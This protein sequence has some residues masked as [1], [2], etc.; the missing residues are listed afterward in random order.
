M[1]RIVAEVRAQG[2]LALVCAATGLAA[3]LYEGG[4]TAHSL[5][6]IPIED[7]ADLEDEEHELK[8]K[9]PCNSQ[10]L[11]LLMATNLVVWDEFPNQH[12]HS[13]EAAYKRSNEHSVGN[14]RDSQ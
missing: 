12:R 7:E 4:T 5:F 13:F 9:L 2:G 3:T 10:R 1:K 11:E 8:C 14:E 6:K